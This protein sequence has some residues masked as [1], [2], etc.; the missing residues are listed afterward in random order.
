MKHIVRKAYWDYEKE[1]KWLN[2]MSAKGLM[3]TDYSWYRYVFEEG[4][5]GAYIYRIE[6]LPNWHSHPESVAYIRFL[7]ESGVE[8][9]AVYMRWIYLRKKVS[10]GPFD[11][12][13]DVESRIGHYKRVHTFWAT[14]MSMDFAA[15]FINAVVVVLSLIFP[16]WGDSFPTTN[17]VCAGVMLVIG[18]L[19]LRL[20][21]PIRKKIRKLK[22]E[23]AVRE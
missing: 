18:I 17:A 21:I 11:I 15:A 10:E 12:Y 20:G 13:S 23:K 6:L 4:P 1:E 3:L 16:E 8:C 5:K 22:K 7:E 2:E 19:L 9:M 14:L